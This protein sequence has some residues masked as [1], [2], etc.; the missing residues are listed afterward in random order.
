MS[1][2]FTF[3]KSIYYLVFI[4]VIL[5]NSCA[6]DSSSENKIVTTNSV[7]SNIPDT[8]AVDKSIL[9]Y[10]YD[11]TYTDS[12]L[13]C[14]Q[15]F[16]KDSLL[17]KEG[18]FYDTLPVTSEFIDHY[19]ISEAKGKATYETFDSLICETGGHS[20][21]NKYVFTYDG[22]KKPALIK[23]YKAWY[24]NYDDDEH[25]TTNSKPYYELAEQIYFTYSAHKKE[26]VTKD[27]TGKL[28]EK[29]TSV[30]DPQSRLAFE[31]GYYRDD[32]RFRIYYWYK[33]QP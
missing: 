29:I 21:W 22:A 11:S 28:I 19:I 8:L 5:L 27:E 12:T 18:Q 32:D 10:S 33:D 14:R 3:M 7:R 13:V 6:N 26:Q 16:L 17:K 1:I 20:A 4:T 15:W 2:N 24:E 30:T 23:H 25:P 31:E 9:I